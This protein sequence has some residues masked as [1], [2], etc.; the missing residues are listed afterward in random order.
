MLDFLEHFEDPDVHVSHSSHDSHPTSFYVDCRAPPPPGLEPQLLCPDVE[1]CMGYAGEC[2]KIKQLFY[3]KR[4][5][6]KV[7]ASCKKKYILVH[8]LKANLWYKC[9]DT[10]SAGKD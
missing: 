8:V 10:A 3:N 9:C 2:H 4:L 7:P 5:V 6:M 1:G